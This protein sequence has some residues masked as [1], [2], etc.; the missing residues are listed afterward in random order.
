M[1]TVIIAGASGLVGSHLLRLLLDEKEIDEVIALVRKTLPITHT[2]LKQKVVSFTE[3][4]SFEGY[5]KGSAVFCCLGSTRKK[6]PD[7]NDYRK[8]D[9]TYPLLLAK[10]ASEN[11]VEQFHLVSA[12]GADPGSVNFYSK[13]K[14]ET[15]RDIKLLIFKSLH[16]YKP[17][18][19]TGNRIEKRPMERF[20]VMVMNIIN[21][22]LRGSLKKYQSIEAE[23][24]ARAMVKQYLKDLDETF[25]YPSDKIK[26]LV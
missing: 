1:K 16:I 3:T 22:M 13:L 23:V 26:E 21:P 10:I 7:L 24:V 5:L 12:L 6:T 25:C 15:E 14:G 8:V 19:L 2:K 17:S 20:A 11:N 4:G 18:L 9:Y